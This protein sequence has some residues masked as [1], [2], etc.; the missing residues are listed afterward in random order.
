MSIPALEARSTSTN[1][2]AGVFRTVSTCI[3]IPAGFLVGVAHLIALPLIIAADKSFVA[4]VE[5]KR[6]REVVRASERI[7][8]R[9]SVGVPDPMVR[10]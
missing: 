4:R 6:R 10:L 3:L 7:A 9:E 2:T 1:R 5:R 8:Y